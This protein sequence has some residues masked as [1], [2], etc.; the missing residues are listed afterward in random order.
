MTHWARRMLESEN[1][2]AL[3]IDGMDKAIIGIA[4][5]QYQPGHPVYLRS[6]I[7]R[8]L[9]YDGME[10]EDAEEYFSFNIEGA[11]LGPHTPLIMYGNDACATGDCSCDEP[12]DQDESRLGSCGCRDYH[13]ADCPTRT[14]RGPVG[15]QE[16]DFDHDSTDPYA[17]D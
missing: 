9:M 6:L 16:D 11:Y 4:R 8:E 5:R 13:M 12:E 17:Y 2:D 7:I 1:P 10:Q 15:D 3:F 14:D